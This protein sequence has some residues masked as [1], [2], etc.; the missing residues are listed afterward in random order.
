MAINKP[1]IAGQPATERRRVVEQPFSPKPAPPTDEYF[2]LDDQGS[3]VFQDPLTPENEGQLSF[4]LSVD[5]TSVNRSCTIYVAVD[6]DGTLTWKQVV[7]VPS[8]IG[9]YTGRPYDPIYD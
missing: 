2:E 7:P 1:R 5:D 6:I 8:I 3:L 4:V 9:K